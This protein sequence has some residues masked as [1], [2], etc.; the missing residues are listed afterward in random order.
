MTY[1][2][3][4]DN[5]LLLAI[6]E[7]IFLGFTNTMSMI[8]YHERLFKRIPPFHDNFES[9]MHL[10]NEKCVT[11]YKLDKNY[12]TVMREIKDL[13][14]EHKKSPIEFTRKDTFVICSEDYK[15]KTLSVDQ[16]KKYIQ[17]AKTFFR[18]V[19]VIVSK[20]EKIFSGS[21]RGT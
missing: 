6:L 11:V 8:L 18:E 4:K 12:M 1:P 21:K 7:N 2:L 15:I 13:I 16:I 10:F 20:N 14:V 3:V 9:K 5:R 17:Q 19:D